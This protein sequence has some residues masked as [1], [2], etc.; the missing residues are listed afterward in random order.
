MPSL[1]NSR[2]VVLS[3][4]ICVATIPGPVGAVATPESS[5]ITIERGLIQ[6]ELGNTASISL[7]VPQG[8]NATLSIS[9][10]RFD[11]AIRVRDV[12]SDGAVV[13]EMDTY[14]PNTSSTNTFTAVSPDAIVSVNERSP[15]QIQPSNYLLQLSV[16]GTQQDLSLLEIEP[17]SFAGTTV[18]VA[19]KD[20][21]T[22]GSVPL[23]TAVPSNRSIARGDVA[24]VTFEAGG[25]AGIGNYEN[26]PGANVV[27]PTTSLPNERTTHT[28]QVST[29]R[30]SVEFATASVH[31]APTDGQ[32]SPKLGAVALDTMGIDTDGDGQIERN[33]TRSVAATTGSDDTLTFELSST[34]ELQRGER[35]LIEY[36]GVQNPD[37]TGNSPVEVEV[38][39]YT[40][41][42]QITYGMAGYGAFGNGVGVNVTSSGSASFVG[43][44]P[45]DY[46]IDSADDELHVAVPTGALQASGRNHSITVTAQKTT[47][48]TN[49]TV[50]DHQRQSTTVQIA[51]PSATIDVTNRSLWSIR[52]ANG[53]ISGESNLAPG[54]QITITVMVNDSL[55]PEIQKQRTV[56]GPD[57]EFSAVFDLLQIVYSGSIEIRVH[58]GE[59][60]IS[61]SYY[62]WFDE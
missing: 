50:Q 31:Y 52:S 4:L 7:S 32:A 36:S 40:K 24:V 8:D 13:V 42:G 33:I 45:Y 20:S 49:G 48:E 57:Q 39:S 19:P 41:T 18:Q 47:F 62:L 56:V 46:A 53:T 34:Y 54:S 6:E 60:Q 2:V 58:D 61:K 16:D 23:E 26:P 12:N 9:N 38:G 25:I 59:T 1:I 21:Y 3:F 55:T 22:P 5:D 15:V 11:R 14:T 30:S 27:Y 10:G 35:L 51:D 44:L 28:V 17:G 29:N 43:A 37:V